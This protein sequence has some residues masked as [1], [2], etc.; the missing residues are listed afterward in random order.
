MPSIEPLTAAFISGS[1]GDN[2]CSTLGCVLTARQ[3]S[4]AENFHELM[5][6]MCCNHRQR[7]MWRGFPLS[8]RQSRLQASSVL[9]R[10]SPLQIPQDLFRGVFAVEAV[11]SNVLFD[12]SCGSAEFLCGCVQKVTVCRHDASHQASQLRGSSRDQTVLAMSLFGLVLPAFGCDSE[13]LLQRTHL[14]LPVYRPTD[15]K[16]NTACKL[17][18]QANLE[19]HIS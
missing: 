8:C 13:P 1:A 4:I 2:A 7:F 12:A 10:D 17:S 9:K 5:F 18:H 11:A 3:V 14:L 6:S 16:P 15:D 19:V